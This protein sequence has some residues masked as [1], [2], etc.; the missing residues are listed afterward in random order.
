MDIRV[1][2]WIE[3]K[4]F[5]PE[6]FQ[7]N[8]DEPLQGTIEYRKK[9][10]DGIVQRTREHWK[11][12]IYEA[13]NHKGAITKIHELISQLRPALQKIKHENTTVC[14]ELVSHCGDSGEAHGFYLPLD[15]IA[16]L[17][18]VGASLDI[19]QYYHTRGND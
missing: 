10:E 18:E 4:E 9:L 7:S 6:E 5:S 3:G 2:V 15:T 11:S 1:S 14:A 13:K 19:D 12:P 8:L 17:A 16:L